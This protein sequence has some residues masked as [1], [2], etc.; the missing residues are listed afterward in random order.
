MDTALP[1]GLLCAV[2]GMMLAFIP[3]RSGLLGGLLLVLFA[4]GGIEI[5][6]RPQVVGVVLGGCWAS[7]VVCALCV[8]WPRRLSI[9]LV[10]FLAANAGIWSGLALAT[11]ADG[12]SS[13]LPVAALLIGLPASLAVHKGYQIAPRVVTSWLLAVAMIAAILPLVVKHP[14]YV[15]DHME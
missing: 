11:N 1:V 13:L 9:P 12:A 8:F 3:S 15:A 5:P 7:L 2:A 14:G 10:Y 4:A 6:A